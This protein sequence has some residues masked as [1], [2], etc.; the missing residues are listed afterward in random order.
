MNIDKVDGV[1]CFPDLDTALA[2][3]HPDQVIIL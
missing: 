2:G 3:N 1:G